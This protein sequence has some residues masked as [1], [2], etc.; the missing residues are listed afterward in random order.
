MGG[1]YRAD[2]GE[3]QRAVAL[4][5][6]PQEVVSDAD[7]LSRFAQEARA[8]SALN[9]PHL[10]AIYEIGEHRIDN[11]RVHVIAMELVKG[12]TLRELID[13][14]ALDLRQTI[15][16]LRANDGCHRPQHAEGIIP[17]RRLR[18]RYAASHHPRAAASAHDPRIHARPP[19]PAC[20]GIPVS[21]RQR[22]AGFASGYGQ[23]CE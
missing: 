23:G 11:G 18:G 4:K 1:V 21:S 6:L 16:L 2:D 3:L 9:H 15:Q 14:R 8:A 5:V 7:R 20:R 17:S 22:I 10:V 19:R 12:K 13:A